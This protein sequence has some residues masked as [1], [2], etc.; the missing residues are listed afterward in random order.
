MESFLFLGI[1]THFHIIAQL[2]KTGIRL[3]LSRNHFQ[4]GGL[5]CAVGADESHCFSLLIWIVRSLKR[6][7][8]P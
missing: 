7:W 2:D 3:L 4:D 1:V 8:L 6:I 5:A